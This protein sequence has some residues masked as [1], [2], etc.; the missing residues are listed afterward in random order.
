MNATLRPKNVHVSR[1]VWILWKTFVC[2]IVFFIVSLSSPLSARQNLKFDHISVE[3]GLS[4]ERIHCI[5]QDSKGF[6]WFGTQD[7][8][9]R[10]DGYTITVYK[11]DRENSESLSYNLVYSIYEDRAGVL[12]IGTWYGGLNKFN[13]ETGT[14]TRYQHDPTDPQ[15][16][17][18]NIIRS[19]FEDRSGV[20]WLGT[21]GGGLN[22]FDRETGSF[23]RYQHDSTNPQSLSSDAVY[24]VYEDKSGVLW[25]GANGGLNKFDRET[26]SFTRY[27]HDPTNP[28]SLSSDVVWSIYEDRSGVLWIGT[29]YGLDKFNRETETFT[30]YQYDPIILESSSGYN[31]VTSIYESRT[32]ELWIGTFDAGLKRF[33]RETE[34]FIDYQG[35]SHNNVHSIYEDRSGVLWIGTKYGLNRLNRRKEHFIHYQHDDKE[36]QSLS[37]NSVTAL[38]EDRSGVLWIGTE[39]GLNKFG[40]E[41]ETFTHYQHDSTNPQSLSSDGVFSIYEDESGV[42]WIGTS[43]GLNKF[44]RDTKQ[45]IHYQNDPNDP[46]TL[47]H[48]FVLSIYEDRSGALWIGTNGGGLNRFDRETEI[49]THY[50]HDSTD[51]QSLGSDSVTSI[52]E[53]QSG[54]LWIG[55]WGGGLNKFNRNTEQF[56]R[57]QHDSADSQSLSD[58]Y[59]LSIYEDRSGRFW[60]GTEFGGLNNFDR[61]NE[62]FKRYT[63]QD[64]LPN[65]KVRGILEDQQENLWLSTKKGLS[66]FDPRAETF[67]NYDMR[68]GLQGYEFDDGAYYKSRGGQMFFGGN[69]GFNAF[70]PEK[71]QDN[72]HI[73]P[74][75]FTDFQ[76]FNTSVKIAK[77]SPLQQ[78]ITETKAITL[79]YKQ[80]VFSFEFAALDYTIPEKNVYAYKMEGFDKDWND[81]GARRIATY[82]NLP[83]GTFTFRVK[84]SN[85]D[86]VWNEEGTSIRI[87]IT[88]PPWKTWWAYSLY[89]MALIGAILGYVRYRTQAQAKEI[90]RQR[91]ELEQERL[92]SERLRQVD[93]LKDDFLA[94]TSHELRTPLQGIIGIAESL[95]DGVAGEQSDKGRTNLS[96]IISSGKRL[97]NLVNDLLDFSKL[98]KQELVLQRKAVDMRTLTEVVLR[99][100]E[101]LIAGKD[102]TLKNEIGED[103]P[104]VDGDEN[105]LQQIMYNLVGNAIKFTESGSVTVSAK[106]TPP[107]PPSRGKFSSDSPPGRGEGWVDSPLEGGQGGVISIS[108]SDTGIGIPQDKIGEIFQSFEQVDASISREYGGTGL[109][110]SI[111][112]QLVELHGGTI[113]VE[114]EVGKGSRFTFTLPIAE[115]MPEPMAQGREV[116]KLREVPENLPQRHGD[117]EKKT[118]S[119]GASVSPWQ[120]EFKIL[121]VDD[122]PIN[123]QVLANHLSFGNYVVTQAF[124]GE[125]ALQA[126][127]RGGTFDLVLLDIMMPRISGYEVCQK[128]REK[129]LPSELPV[130]MITAKNQVSDLVEGFSSGANDYLAKPFSKDELLARIRTHL[131][132][133]NINTAYG[134][135]VPNE[136]LR[137]L[138]RESILDVKLGD[139]IQGAMTVLFSD[140]RSFTSISE[141]M[142]PKENFEF[143]NEYLKYVIPPIRQHN[144]FIDKYIG[145][146]VMAIFPMSSEDAV[147]ASIGMLKQLE[148]Y[149]RKSKLKFA[150]QIGVGL[151]TGT[152][153]LGTIG[154]EDRMDGTVISD[155]V[156]LASRLEGLT[157]K[158]GASI[159]ISE[160]T[161]TGIESPEQYHSRFLG[162]V[163]VKGKQEAVAVFEVYDGDPERIRE[164]KMNTTSDFEEGLHHYFVREFIKAA[165]CFKKVLTV[166]PDDKTAKLYLERSA[167]FMVQG[168]P[169]DWQGVETMESK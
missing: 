24:S 151:H 22:K 12:W 102:L 145:D 143:L 155:T 111:T 8:L 130:I 11:H 43:S 14:F 118:L 97:S 65:N 44:E 42:L 51:P 60:I 25:V 144:G 107:L 120:P 13:R 45:F 1:H 46:Q 62:T 9:N 135:F 77:D 6:M 104:P 94:N 127:E 101:P 105:R 78:S 140:I 152:L 158:Y 41:T 121:V 117:T 76:L 132:L 38:Y 124:T 2:L 75:V 4:D 100:S 35:L 33:V 63:E 16:L 82:T 69:N 66:K 32:E 15:S 68:D 112:K 84:G 116:A 30:H 168:V 86:G 39:D 119:L 18:S 56:I 103:I 31:L 95:F 49:F 37:S 126:I 164:L 70:Y 64:G 157:K 114:S 89:I 162:K 110:L 28:Q 10:Y 53:D 87:T 47:S 61:A 169:G 131:N 109:G 67:K 90:A 52:Y 122:E 59:I 147:K 55:T 128:I 85:N 142:T 72:P 93:Q 159:I 74:I 149:N 83:A 23:T 91:K 80:D 138:G 134:R 19:I 129:Y 137:T 153:M 54:A 163:Q 36:P 88:P 48:N 106:V 139:Q 96:M 133:L 113:R 79:S 50:Q 20:L 160:D 58:D 166:N 161:L 165:A 26:G 115:G 5:L 73:P 81:V 154:D 71:I 156:N 3:Q 27:Q 57:Y 136:F 17:S 99:L 21:W 92:L 108:V 148:E 7:G 141:G 34:Q 167:Q 123:H 29:Q 146:A 125:E 150:L 40:R 98:K